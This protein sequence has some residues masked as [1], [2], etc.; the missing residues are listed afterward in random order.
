MVLDGETREPV[1]GAEVSLGRGG[2]APAAR[3]AAAAGQ[4]RTTSS[5]GT[6]GFYTY[7]GSKQQVPLTLTVRKEGYVTA[8]PSAIDYAMLAGPLRVPLYRENRIAGRVVE[9]KDGEPVAGV[10]VRALSAF[11]ALGR[12]RLSPATS[13]SKTEK[14][15]RF[16]IGG[17]PPGA[18]FLET[19]PRAAP[20]ERIAFEFTEE[21]AKRVDEDYTRV[22]WPPFDLSGVSPIES[23][24][25]S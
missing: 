20:A 6:F 21:D 11:V 14:D 10:K 7:V 23:G 22:D 4:T 24:H 25:G 8:G 3:G 15:G 16:T 19:Q 5:S 1:S 13:E 17:L 2:G 18:Y 12:G 9:A